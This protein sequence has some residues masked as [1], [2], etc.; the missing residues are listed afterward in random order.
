VRKSPEFGNMAVKQVRISNFTK[1]PVSKHTSR[2]RIREVKARLKK[3][4]LLT[5]TGIS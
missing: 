3:K 4:P 2:K 1:A 5:E